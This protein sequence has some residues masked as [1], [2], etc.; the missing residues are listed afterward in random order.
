MRKT[1]LL[2]LL[3][4]LSINSSFAKD[5]TLDFLKDPLGSYIQIS[6]FGFAKDIKPDIANLNISIQTED[7][8]AEKA[9]RENA[10]IS[11]TVI[12]KLKELGIGKDKIETRNFSISPRYKYDK[13]T[14]T[15]LG[16]SAV[17][18]LNVEVEPSKIGLVIDSVTSENISVG[19]IS[20]K[21]NDEKKLLKEREALQNAVRDAR[22][23]AEI[24]ASASGVK[25]K[26]VKY[27]TE[28]ISRSPSPYLRMESYAAKASLDAPTQIAP[29]DISVS[30]SVSIL[31]EID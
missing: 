29:K 26:G 3:F 27:I 23:K 30:K 24:I 21:L 17:N 31:F 2:S 7:K 10:N 6:G 16:Y 1:I 15:K 8:T 19:G 22:N 13:G 28:G 12:Q 18:S 9:S 4:T 11:N 25:I 5:K 14:R 20:Y